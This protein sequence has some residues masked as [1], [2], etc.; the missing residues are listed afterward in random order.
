MPLELGG[1]ALT[2]PR[3]L[4]LTPT[5]A[6]PVVRKTAT[7]AAG[8]PAR[9]D[10]H[11]RPDRRTPALIALLL[12]LGSTAILWPTQ[13]DDAPATTASDV[14][15]LDVPVT[16]ARIQLEGPA[17]VA[18]IATAAGR[19][20]LNGPGWTGTLAGDAFYWCSTKV[21]DPPAKAA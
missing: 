12:A 17:A 21:P 5:A 11:E 13:P 20:V 7:F 14:L 19:P 16:T 18:G 3:S 1:A 2:A 8:Q 15:K 4:Q 10:D 9:R 6:G